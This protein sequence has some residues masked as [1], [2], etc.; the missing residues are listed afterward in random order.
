MDHR[1]A[2]V[3]IA[4]HHSA[5]WGFGGRNMRARSLGDNLLQ[6]RSGEPLQLAACIPP[7]LSNTVQCEYSY[8]IEG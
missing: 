1:V 3:Q 7:V 2:C 6:Q 4:A 5:P 8:Y